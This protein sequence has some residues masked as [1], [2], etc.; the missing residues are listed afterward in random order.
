MNSGGVQYLQSGG[1]AQATTLNNGGVEQVQ[2]GGTAIG[3]LISAGGSEV[4]SAG[5]TASAAT[6][7]SGGNLTV[8]AGASVAGGLPYP[9][10]TAF[11]AGSVAAGQT[12]GICRHRRGSG[13]RQPRGLRR[14]DQRLHCGRPDRPVQLRPRRWP[15]LRG[16]PLGSRQWSFTEAANLTS[17]TLTVTDGPQ[18]A[19]LTLLGNYSTGSF[20]LSN[21]GAGGILAKHT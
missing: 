19:Q 20:A 11:V 2:S 4:V 17:G 18:Q 6:V 14:H 1:T 10:G 8:N 15:R 13:A 21:D 9:G 5:G 12:L 16:R 3:T 7:F